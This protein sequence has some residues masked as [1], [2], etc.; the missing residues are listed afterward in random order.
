VKDRAE[1]YLHRVLQCSLQKP[2]EEMLEECLRI[3]MELSGA[4]GGSILGEEGSHLQFL[5]ANVPALIGVKVPWESI[6]GNTV[7]RSVVIYTYAPADKRHFSG[8]DAKTA[9]QTRY[10]LS[11]PIPSIHTSTAAGSQPKSSGVLQLLFAGNVLPDADTT[12][13]REFSLESVREQAGYASVLQEVF[14][15]LPNVSFGLEVMRLRQTSYQVIHELKNKLIATESWLNCLGED[16]G[17]RQA[18]LLEDETI[19][20]DMDLARTAAQEGASLAKGYLQFTKIYTPQFRDADINRVLTETAANVRTFAAG[21]GGPG[22]EVVTELAPNLA[23]RQVDPEQLKMALFNLGKNA[24]EALI[25][26]GVP[27][28][29]VRLSSVLVDGRLHLTVQDNGRGMPPE[30]A[31]SLFVAFKTRKRG[32]TGLGLTI[33][34]KIVDVHGGLIRCETGSSGTRFII[35]L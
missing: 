20:E 14:C 22:L 15:L 4:T 30:I 8:I 28:P 2:P 24:A 34:K 21:N 25:E 6:A 7:R 19:R 29:Q 17:E 11:I 5:F 35:E 23:P 10:L 32:G 12:T 1:S 31:S 13:P 3:C 18:A 9:Q 16:I 27:S 33:T 26:H